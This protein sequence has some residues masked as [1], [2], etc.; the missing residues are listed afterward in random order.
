M[1]A[2]LL[3][4]QSTDVERALEHA[5][6]LD[7]KAVPLEHIHNPLTCDP[8]FLPFLAW[9]L[10]VDYWDDRWP[11]PLKRN[12][13]AASWIVH[14]YKGTVFAVRHALAALEFNA[15]VYEWFEYNGPRGTFRVDV[16]LTD[17]GVTDEEYRAALAVV[18]NA[19]NT[20]S[21]L[22]SLTLSI[23]SDAACPVGCVTAMGQT[24]E[25]MPLVIPDLRA[26]SALQITAGTQSVHTIDLITEA[27][28]VL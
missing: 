21:H 14:R 9:A 16:D 5:V 28:H 23:A 10:S 7:D 18:Q 13:V 11:L 15:T 20:R 8:T 24:I 17:R 2:S 4:P 3:P 6:R 25:V 22:D 19:K 12:V 1:S 26:Q 27:I